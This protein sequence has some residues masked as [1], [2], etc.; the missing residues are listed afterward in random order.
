VSRVWWGRAGTDVPIRLRRGLDLPIPGAPE[1]VIHAASRPHTVG[2]LVD[3]F[4]GLRL[5]VQVQMGDRVRTGQTLFTDRRRPEIRFNAPATG[6]VVAIERGDT[7]NLVAVVLEVDDD[8]YISFAPATEAQLGDASREQIVERLLETGEWVGLR[9]RP[10]GRI[11]DPGAVPD[12]IFVRAMDS[13]PLAADAAVVLGERADDLRH[14]LTALARLTDGPVFVCASPGTRPTLPQESRVRLVEFEGP[15]PAG[16]VGTHI[17]HLLPVSASRRV[18]YAGYQDVLAIGHVLRTGR[19]NPERV[20]SLAGP[21]VRRPRLLRTRLGA[22]SEDLVRDELEPGD[23]RVISGSVLDGRR[24][25]RPGGFLGRYHEQICAIG[26]REPPRPRAWLVP[27]R[28]HG[29]RVPAWRGRGSWE[30][31]VRSPS[32]AMLPLDVFE[33]VVP[34]RLPISLLLRSL[35]ANDFTAARTYGALELEEEDLAL[36]S[37]LCPSKLEYGA[38]LRGALHDL[39]AQL[40]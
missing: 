4:P 3:D 13:Q 38:L 31:A 27:G 29:R 17:H 10:L 21:L 32:H 25:A 19:L 15:H 34:L 35:A 2:F 39:E 7:R 36:C 11:P 33:R 6:S 22:S 26:E 40:P 1:Q 9:T 14:G 37:Y 12:A 20:I 18:W 28:R 5:S 8:E 23:C 30:A 24:A 16:L